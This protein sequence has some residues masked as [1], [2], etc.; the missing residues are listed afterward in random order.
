MVCA[1]L[2]GVAIE[3]PL[4][5]TMGLSFIT[6]VAILLVSTPLLLLFSP[7]IF[8]AGLVLGGAV[9]GFSVAALMAMS[10]LSTLEW[11]FTKLRAEEMWDLEKEVLLGRQRRIG[12]VICRKICHII[13]EIEVGRSKEEEY[14]IFAY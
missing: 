5:G 14:N 13:I 6:S 8:F 1:S 11:V 4:L 2:A 10:G 12:L 7:I 3:G 9:A